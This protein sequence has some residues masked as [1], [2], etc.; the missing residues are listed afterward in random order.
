MNLTT[1]AYLLRFL[2]PTVPR[3]GM[4]VVS[5]LVAAAAFAVGK[6]G[7]PRGPGWLRLLNRRSAVVLVLLVVLVV[8]FG[9]RVWGIDFGL[10]QSYYADE[11]DF[12][13]SYLKMIK[14]GDFNPRWWVHPSL[15]AYVNVATYVVVFL[16]GVPSGRWSSVHQLAE[17]DMLFWGRLGAGVI[18]G[19]LT[20]L[21]TFLLG[22]R[23]FGSGV[24]L[25]A[26]ALMAVSPAATQWS[27][28]NRPEALLTLLVPL[29]VFVILYYFDLGGGRL[30][31]ACGVVIGLTAAA[32]YN[33]GFVVLPFIFSVILRQRS[34]FLV[35]PDLY[36][37][38]VGTIVGFTMGCPYW[39]ADFTRF[40]DDIAASLR[41]Y[42][43]AG[44]SVGVGE[45]NW[46]FHATYAGS[47]GMGWLAFLA[48]LVGLG[49]LLNRLDGRFAVFL[50][51]PLLY[52]GYYSSQI[53]NKPGNLICIYPF[54]TVMA[55]LGIRE[56]AAALARLVS[57]EKLSRAVRPGVVAVL[58]VIGLWA[59]LE[60][61]MAHN[62]E[63]NRP[64][65]GNI[66]RLWI[67]A[68]VP[69]GAHFAV[70]RHS[71]VPDGKRFRVTMVA[72][73]I[74]R[75]VRDYALDGVQY[76]V[77]SSAIYKRF[78]SEHR[79][80]K[81]YEKLFAICPLVKE[82]APREGSIVGPTMRILQVP[83]FEDTP[84]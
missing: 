48:A 22:R 37:G 39:L 60:K 32:K 24:G 62:V 25:A 35:V 29:S 83:S 31:F 63:L 55:A 64:D 2:E 54:L 18:P 23:L 74:N 44:W 41:T 84:S 70:E 10:P 76:L 77:V 20:V 71:V 38:G 6:F 17:E 13:H 72:R 34:R 61:T 7:L 3:N 19:T 26:A 51:F 30:A 45:N 65:T 78:D 58:L 8:A 4:L 5:I 82:F 36:L 80:T 79:R 1:N 43:H 50:S 16:A 67:D 15:Q 52:Y 12:V 9:L 33:G 57:S 59:P 42:G 56:T 47:F 69:A 81:A 28:Y 49:V 14:R 53:V 21:M 40:V 73:V 46:I 68:H 27:Q 11:Y 66:A 75:A